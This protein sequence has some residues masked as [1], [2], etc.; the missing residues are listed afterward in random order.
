MPKKIDE[1]ALVG[2]RLDPDGKVPLYV[3]IYNYFK[4][5]IL[6]QRLRSG[7]RLPGT[8]SLAAE[9]EVSRNTVSL[10]FEQLLIEGY[11]EG[12]TGSGSYVAETIPDYLLPDLAEVQHAP[13]ISHPDIPNS[14]QINSLKLKGINTVKD[15]IL[16]FQTGTPALFDFPLDLWNRIAGEVIKK[17]NPIDLGYGDSAGYQPLRATLAEYLRTYRAVKC[18]TEQIVIVNGSQQALNLIGKVLLSQKS[19][20]W[21]EDPG[22]SGAR[23]SII[24]TG[25]KIFPVPLNDE[26]IDLD[27]AIRNYPKPNLI[28]TTPSHQYPLGYTMSISRRLQL[29]DWGRKNKVWIVEDDYDSEYRYAGNPLPSLQGLNSGNGVI[30]TGTFS[31]VLFPGLRLGYMVLPTREI[32]ELFTSAKS[33]SD[34]QSSIMDQMITARFIEEGHFTKH[35]RKMRILYKDRQD[36]LINEIKRELSDVVQVEQADAGMH[37]IARLPEDYDDKKIRI[38]ALDKDL[39]T[40]AM[41]EYAMHF[42]VKPGLLLGYTAFDKKRLREGV[43]RL[44]NV[45]S[46]YSA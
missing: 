38:L 14:E 28:Y 27:Y 15:E 37:L 43:R 5:S 26:G 3:Q 30:Y 18:E 10:A 41:S 25:A 7:Q 23:A 9:L 29:L 42:P 21:I 12:R 31:K 35:I 17:V 13:E 44:V 6:A 33:M 22:Y 1:I 8:R 16:P 32:A 24:T 39:V 11:I 34:R 19:I 46:E 45:L 40:P 2:I 36:F 20:V 4:E